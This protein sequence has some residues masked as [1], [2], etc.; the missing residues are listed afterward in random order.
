MKFVRTVVVFDRGGL[1][2][3]EPWARMHAAYRAAL[4]AV[5][6]PC[7][8]GRWFWWGRWKQWRRVWRRR[9]GAVMRKT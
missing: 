9:G 3:S 4:G 7:V 5:V 2:E 1:M 8:P 6:Q